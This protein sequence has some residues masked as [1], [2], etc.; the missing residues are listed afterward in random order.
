ME[1]YFDDGYYVR[2]F[3]GDYELDCSRFFNKMYDYESA[4]KIAKNLVENHKKEKDYY[5]TIEEDLD[6]CGD[7][8]VVNK[9]GTL[10]GELA[11]EY[12]ESFS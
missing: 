4:L 7:V 1:N 12:I 9:N 2:E 10:Y 8:V 5:V 11:E 3:I 6:A